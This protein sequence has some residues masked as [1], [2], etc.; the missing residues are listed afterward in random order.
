MVSYLNRIK[1]AVER[2][3]GCRIYGN[4]LP[5]GMDLSFDIDRRFGRNNIQVVFDV[6]A[7]VGQ[8]TLAYL[9]EFPQARIY[10]FEP[11]Q[12]TYQKLSEA[13]GSFP[14]V[15][16]F[17]L[18]MGSE[19]GETVIH[20]NPVSTASSIVMERA[21]D[22]AESIAMET[23]AGFAGKHGVESIDL[24]KIDTEGYDLEVLRGAAPLLQQQRIHL[25]QSEC[26]PSVRSREDSP[27]VDF[28][29]LSSF[30]N[31]F[32]YELFGVYEQQLEWDGRNRVRYWNAVF[33]CPKLIVRGARLTHSA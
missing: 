7:N 13:T 30:L 23:V 15:Q 31:G 17:K 19:A 32:G 16:A 18:G 3:A 4:S 28:V 27:F 22:R 6:G 26:E 25:I 9:R 8:S 2:A 11:V 12:S 10:S 1:R 21:G 29:S 5:H 33:L 20:V 14:R 24:L